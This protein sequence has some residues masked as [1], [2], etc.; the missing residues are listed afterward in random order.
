MTLATFN[1]D[2]IFLGAMA[3]GLTIMGALGLVLWAISARNERRRLRAARR[4]Q[5]RR[6]PS[7]L[8]EVPAGQTQV[9]GERRAA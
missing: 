8:F 1:A 2:L 9:D 6:T 7:P 5:M 4:E 3:T